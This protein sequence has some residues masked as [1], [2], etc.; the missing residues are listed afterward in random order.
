[1]SFAAALA[2]PHLPVAVEITPPRVSRPDILRRRAMLLGHAPDAVNVIQRPDRQSSL[3]ASCELKAA[4][5]EPVLHLVA[6]GTSEAALESA[7]ERACAST[8]Q[9]VLCILGDLQDGPAL[10]VKDLVAASVRSLPGA[11]VGA[12]LNQY[13]DRPDRAIAN[14]LGKLEAGA[15]FVETQPVFDLRVLEPFVEQA[16]KERP[17]TRF[18]AM[19]MPITSPDGLRRM[20]ARLRINAPGDYAREVAVG[21]ESA[22]HAFARLVSD[23]RRSGLVDGIALM[24]PDMD[25]LPETVAH[26]AAALRE[27]GVSAAARLE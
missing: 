22:W 1:M 8:I 26:I 10:R 27:A 14:L 12:T 2:S 17:G 11:I 23:L 20:E 6:R 4:G 19:V 3:D 13:G 25:P 5:F 16:R 15:T 21:T 9:N 7:L 18:V 24:T